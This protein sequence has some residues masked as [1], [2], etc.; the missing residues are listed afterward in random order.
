M[1]TLILRYVMADVLDWHCIAKEVVGAALMWV[2]YLMLLVF[3]GDPAIAELLPEWLVT[4]LPSLF[5]ITIVASSLS[6]G[7]ASIKSILPPLVLW[8]LA[9]GFGIA[10]YWITAATYPARWILFASAVATVLHGIGFAF[11]GGR[12]S[13]ASG[14]K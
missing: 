5:W 12:H 9:V 7:V 3:I 11:F 4:F 2:S 6:I 1:R 8:L 13:L 10:S 14:R